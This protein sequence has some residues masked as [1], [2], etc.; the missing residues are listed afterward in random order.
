MPSTIKTILTAD[1]TNV[2]KTLKATEQYYKDTY[3]TMR[4]LSDEQLK[5]ESRL[6]TKRKNL[7]KTTSLLQK[8]QQKLKESNKK[9]SD[10][11]KEDIKT[12]EKKI[13][14]LKGIEIEQK[15]QIKLDSVLLSSTKRS[16]N[17]NKE[18]NII[19]K[20]RIDI[21]Q[22]EKLALDSSTSAKNSNT[23]AN[24]KNAIANN[25]NAKS[26]ESARNSVVRHLRQLETL[27]VAY[28]SLT[29]AWK[30]TL[31][32]GIEMNKM[33]ESGVD[34][35]AALTSANTR[36][37]DSLGNTLDPLQKFI[38]GQT[39]AKDSMKKLREE[40]L[41]TPA[42]MS[43]LTGIY[44]Q[45]KGPAL[46]MGD[47]FGKSVAEIDKN[48][49]HLA[50]LFSQ[51]GGAINMEMGKVNE[52]IRSMMTGNISTDSI[53]ST[54][55][56]GTPTKANAVVK[57]AQKRAGGMVG[58]MNEKFEA[59]SILGDQQTFNKGLLQMQGAYE[60][61]MGDMVE[62]S[63]MFSDMTDSFYG[64]SK[65]IR[66]G[67]DDIVDS[68]DGMYTSIKENAHILGTTIALY[69]AYKVGGL[70][71]KGIS[72]ALRL[73]KEMLTVS[74]AMLA[75]DVLSSSIKKGG[76]GAVL[77]GA[78]TATAAAGAY[79][80]ISDAISGASD[81]MSE[82]ANSNNVKTLDDKFKESTEKV[83]L[84]KTELDG[85]SSVKQ[86]KIPAL[87]N[88]TKLSDDRVAQ[89]KAQQEKVQ[90]MYNEANKDRKDQIKKELDLEVQKNNVLQ[91]VID[92]NN[93]ATLLTKLGLDSKLSKEAETYAKSE[94]TRLDKLLRHREEYT[95]ELTRI[96]NIDT[97]T[98][99]RTKDE[100][101]GIDKKQLE[102]K[103][104]IAKV[105][106]EIK[107]I[108]QDRAAKLLKAQQDLWVAQQKIA[109]VEVSRSEIAMFG[110]EAI[111]KEILLA[112]E[113][114]KLA[115]D[116]K[117]KA[118]AKVKLINLEEKQLGKV[119]EWNVAI[120]KEGEKQTKI[121][122]KSYKDA[123]KL[124][125]L[126]SA[127]IIETTSGSDSFVSTSEYSTSFDEINS[128]Y[129][130]L[131]LSMATANDKTKEKFSKDWRDAL[132]D[133][134]DEFRDNTF[135]IDIKINGFDEISNGIAGVVNGF[136]DILNSNAQLATQ[137]KIASNAQVKYV[138][139]REDV[140]STYED[141]QKALKLS[142]KEKSKSDDM[143]SKNAINQIGNYANMT[144]AMANFY[145]EDDDR[146]KKQEQL[147]KV[148]QASQMTMDA[149]KI[150]QHIRYMLMTEAEALAAGQLAVAVQASA[151]PVT[152][153]VAAA[154]M[155]AMLASIGIA[156]GGSG[157]K[158]VPYES[159]ENKGVGTTFGDTEKQSESIENSLEVI[160]NFAEPQY[161]EIMK[162]NSNMINLSN[163]INKFV[164]RAID[165]SVSGLSEYDTNTISEDYSDI[166]LE[167]LYNN[168]STIMEIVPLIGTVWGDTIDSITGEIKDMLGG[169][170]FGNIVGEGLNLMFG[171]WAD[172]LVSDVM[173]GDIY[174]SLA[175]YGVKFNEQLLTSAIDNISGESFQ[176][177]KSVE[178]GGRF[179][180]DKTTY[181]DNVSELGDELASDMENILGS[182]YD[183]IFDAGEAIGISYEQMSDSLSG[184]M[185][186]SAE[187]SFDKTGEEIQEDFSAYI[188]GLSD[189]LSAVAFED[190]LKPYRDVGEG[191]YETMNRVSLNFAVVSKT[192]DISFDGI[193]T[194][195]MLS[196]SDELIDIFGGLDSFA[197][198]TSSYYSNFFDDEKKLKDATRTIGEVFDD[199]G[200]SAPNTYQEFTNIVDS[201]DLNTESGRETYK[202]LMLSAG[203]FKLVGDSAD[204]STNNIAEWN[205][206]N[207]TTTDTFNRLNK[208]MTDA[209]YTVETL[210]DAMSEA[211]D[212]GKLVTK[213]ELE[214]LQA[215]EAVTD[216]T[217]ANAQSQREFADS[218]NGTETALSFASST[219]KDFD[220]VLPTTTKGLIDLRQAFI[221]NDGVIDT[222][223]QTVIDDT[224]AIA[225]NKLSLDKR[226]A[227]LK[228]TDP[229]EKRKL[230]LAYELADLHS[231]DN[232]DTLEKIY[233]LEDKIK[234]DSTNKT[235]T[236]EL[237]KLGLDTNALRDL[238]TD[239]MD[240][241]TKAIQDKIWAFQ[242]LADA[243]SIIQNDILKQYDE[244]ISISKEFDSAIVGI[245]DLRL[246]IQDL[247][248]TLSKVTNA[249]NTI[250]DASSVV[251]ATAL[252]SE[253]YNQEK[254]I[255]DEEYSDSVTRVESLTD[256]FK[257]LGESI[258]DTI[259]TLLGGSDDLDS[260]DAQIEQFWSKRAE[261]DK[262]LL[263][264][265]NLTEDQQNKMSDL[266][267]DIN[268][269]STGIQDS[270][271][272]DNSI[273]T[274]ELISELTGLKTEI[275]NDEAIINTTSAVAQMEESNLKALSDLEFE[276]LE[277][278]ESL[279]RSTE[280]IAPNLA[281]EI[282]ALGELATQYL[283]TESELSTWLRGWTD[284]T[285]D[286]A[287]FEQQKLNKEAYDKIDENTASTT[288][289]IAA[290]SSY[291][292]SAASSA[293]IDRQTSVG[294]ISASQAID[295][296]S[297]TS[298]LDDS[299]TAW[300]SSDSLEEAYTQILGR[301][302]DDA[303]KVAYEAA[304][305]RGMTMQDVASILSNSNEAQAKGVEAFA[306]G[307]IVNQPTMA[308]FGEAGTEAFVP[309]PDGKTI[310]VTMNN[311]YPSPTRVMDYAQKSSD[312]E[313]KKLLVEI[314]QKL[315][316]IATQDKGFHNEVSSVIKG[317]AMRV[318]EVG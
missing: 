233:K 286:F 153:F 76:W 157:G 74:E 175:D 219:I 173:G 30:N 301:P 127:R 139:L 229:I 26:T 297:Q 258:E 189:T 202:T 88:G 36:F 224:L 308:L 9:N 265:G 223:E 165:I 248:V 73:Q 232:K 272:D 205:Q 300:S 125:N 317:N 137:T 120:T 313:I 51:V 251:D 154:A 267:G 252:I 198:T 98:K 121:D 143:A 52:E 14:T 262:L 158:D 15:R 40:S 276:T 33:M 61:S 207:E 225:T 89:L 193:N 217:E 92:K 12:I 260:Q 222:Y 181:S 315:D 287:T 116:G 110:I 99:A 101:K 129:S 115:D 254:S 119:H 149:I 171:G 288:E 155:A 128:K 45:A 5:V 13:S 240:K 194:E 42:T 118:E 204:L 311:T 226:L 156:V 150:A 3:S 138:S 292:P 211:S 295:Y 112:G 54:M 148:L 227:L 293:F 24:N 307:G 130:D 39:D 242:D 303:G 186:D 243:Q 199:I 214:L 271:L 91:M 270:A 280:S 221:D 206:R 318:K 146:K 170:Y 77:A 183:S 296:L 21:L 84:L 106:S 113:T 249:M 305:D 247:P 8:E 50:T 124:A 238:E 269:L 316:K 63:G 2:R 41:L 23:I 75:V 275:G 291:T 278:L 196:V 43:Q 166:S 231:Q 109:G 261:L 122:E 71:Y 167:N 22:K 7:S 96:N 201:L 210:T 103:G 259:Y 298:T 78:A 55:L 274:N 102:L 145:D 46:A 255:L 38:M 191:L 67:S 159:P 4:D 168:P 239:E 182:I 27:A 160:E 94:A 142:N 126:Q 257:G 79:V 179:S 72:T 68:F 44:M 10:A 133:L 220:G 241:S 237:N 86:F 228:E 177:I 294:G 192:L 176:R 178:D 235:L 282:Q 19:T 48:T 108:K 18:D 95:T 1:D 161:R 162:L 169:G 34:G 104:N 64:F 309:L 105:T 47:A 216:Q 283:G 236:E 100:D 208:E 132:S 273:I 302:I 93:K 107:T 310:P 188:G 268:Q 234:L 289:D 134:N 195:N 263:L 57:E 163:D 28:Y 114:L 141:E 85:L 123:L 256:A 314:S 25:K 185:I 97:S 62:K 135:E 197:E 59:F 290:V 32:I 37:I 56:F 299:K 131:Q 152:G 190:I 312:P 83:K 16:I 304:L 147:S 230:E 245:S 250:S 174:K 65:A 164:A 264:D 281:L 284:G 117:E 6:D 244:I 212:G 266:V 70:V 49:I 277:M 218:L 58:L 200:I 246:S 60:I 11:T 209:G 81:S 29:T 69:S 285:I 172:D 203:A 17:A 31:G 82:M 140:N 253:Y 213:E 90:D 306:N 136:T 35:S 144:G 66:D 111:E 180:S 53:I 20:Q 279:E 215:K 187:I 87:S 151:G 80:L 184:A